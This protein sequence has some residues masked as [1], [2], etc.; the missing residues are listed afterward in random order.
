M[1]EGKKK[2]LKTKDVLVVDQVPRW[3]EF[4]SKK[5]W[6]NAKN[7]PK[8]KIYFPDFTKSKLPER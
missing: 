3:P 8:I 4:S 2:L 6:E 1:L 5:L 7:N